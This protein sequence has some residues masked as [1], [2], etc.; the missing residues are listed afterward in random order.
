MDATELQAELAAAKA[1]LATLTET[2][3]RH[4]ADYIEHR[5]NAA[6]ARNLGAVQKALAASVRSKQDRDNVAVMRNR[7][8]RL[9]AHLNDQIAEGRETRESHLE[10]F[11]RVRR[12]TA[13]VMPFPAVNHAPEAA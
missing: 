2:V 5:A 13:E 1:T 10:L 8:E 11:D 4:H 3:N 7:Q 6:A 9:I 12:V